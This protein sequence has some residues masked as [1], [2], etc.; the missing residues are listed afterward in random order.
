[1]QFE[2]YISTHARCTSH[3][4]RDI[5]L[6][7]R[8]MCISYSKGNHIPPDIQISFMYRGIIFRTSLLRLLS[9]INNAACRVFANML[10]L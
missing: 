7:T 9:L 8:E 5:H 4:V 1:M 2:T 6:N 10:F 3:A